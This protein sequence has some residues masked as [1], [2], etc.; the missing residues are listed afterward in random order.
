[1]L[2]F[3]LFRGLSSKAQYSAR[4]RFTHIIVLHFKFPQALFNQN[5]HLVIYCFLLFLQVYFS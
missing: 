4:A 1:M 2:D 5:L 3:H